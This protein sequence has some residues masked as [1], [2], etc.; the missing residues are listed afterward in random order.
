MK[1]RMLSWPVAVALLL[2]FALSGCKA[3]SAAIDYYGKYIESSMYGGVGKVDRLPGKAEEVI[4]PGNENFDLS[5]VGASAAG[6]F[7]EDEKKLLYGKNLTAKVYPASM[8]KCMTALLVLENVEDLDA[9]VLVTEEAYQNLS[10]DSS[11]AS[12]KVGGTYSVTDL[13]YALLLPSGNE[14]ANAL[15]IYVDGNVTDFVKRMNARA[16]DLGMVDTS[17]KNPHGLH[18][19]GHY[20]T[21]YDLYL[22]FRALIEYPLF[23][24]IA[25]TKK[26]LIYCTIDGETVSQE[27]V[28]TNSFIREYTLPPDGITVVAGKTG[29]TA[30]AGRCLIL[31]ST[32]RKGRRFISVIAHANTYDAVY[33]ETVKLLELIPDESE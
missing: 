16:L 25:G 20:T 29:Y 5:Y 10:A 9:Q 23:T 18:D 14:A 19:A 11:T 28:T 21:V 32:D 4:V 3:G 1:K 2:C 30:S 13:L 7:A 22:L 15:A 8:T 17:F 26:A 6:L 33:E 31:L 12:L 24:E 27:V